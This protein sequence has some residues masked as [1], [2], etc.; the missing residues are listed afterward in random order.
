MTENKQE[1]SEKSINCLACGVPLKIIK[2]QHIEMLGKDF[3]ITEECENCKKIEKQ[4][5]EKNLRAKLIKANIG[6]RYLNLEFSNLIDVSQSFYNAKQSAIKYCKSSG[7]CK[8][9]GLGMYL[10]GDNGRG[11]TAIEAC[12]LK[13]LARQGYSIYL[14]NLTEVVDKIFKNE[15]KLSFLKDVDFLVIDDIGSEKM[16]KTGLD[17][18][19]VAEKSNELISSREKDLKPTLFTS[20]LSISSLLKVGYLKKIVERIYSLSTRI[21]EIESD[22]SYR[23]RPVNELPF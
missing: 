3:P 8:K 7:V 14:T 5:S 12:I 10:F 20:N 23:M 4:E 13:E 17:E 18:T 15:L 2:F 6:S 9:K 19:F 1:N 22:E 21:I 16:T 11:K